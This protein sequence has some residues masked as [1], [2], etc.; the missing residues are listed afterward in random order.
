VEERRAKGGELERV[1]RAGHSRPSED[2]RGQG[3]K[4]LDERMSTARSRSH[5]MPASALLMCSSL[6]LLFFGYESSRAASIA[7]LGA[8]EVG[9]GSEALPFTVALGSPAGALVL[10]LYARSI[11]KNGSRYT[12]RVSNFGCC[13]LLAF[14]TFFSSYF[15]HGGGRAGQALVIF[16]YVFREIYVSL[17]STQHWSFLTSVLDASST[18]YLVSSAGIVSISSAV[19]SCA[20]EVVVKQGGVWQ[21]LVTSFL[22]TMLSWLCAEIAYGITSSTDSSRTTSRPERQQ[23]V[24]VWKDSW[25]LMLGHYTLK[26]LFLEAIL[27]QACSNMLNLMFHDGLRK[28]VTDDSSRA[29][30]V[31]RFFASVNIVA[32]FLQVVVMPRVLSHKTLPMFIKVVPILVLLATSLGLVHEASLISV[33]LGFGCMKVLE[34]SVMT[35]A[36]EMIYMPMGHEVRYL[37]KEL[38]RFFGHRLGKS[39]TSLLLSAA[40]A[41]F[42]PTLRAQ[43]VWSGTLAAVWGASMFLLSAHLTNKGMEKSTSHESNSSMGS[44]GATSSGDLAR[45][46]RKVVRSMSEGSDSH[47]TKGGEDTTSE[48]G[49]DRENDFDQGF[50]YNSRGGSA[51]NFPASDEGEVIATGETDA[52]GGHITPSNSTGRLSDGAIRGSGGMRYRKRQ[53]S[54]DRSS[55]P[56]SAPGVSTLFDASVFESTGYYMSS[57]GSGSKL[58]ELLED[59]VRP[60]GMVRIGSQ[61]VSLNYLAAL[62]DSAAAS[63]SPDRR[64]DK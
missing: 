51:S 45:I 26:L 57:D 25:E 1:A 3:W 46:R 38:I 10:Y 17:L 18:G 55:S 40:S 16:F 52:A 30:L 33:M 31:G 4:R 27:H 11:K 35:S 20:V 21:L 49:S 43:S 39:G 8:K 19:G 6:S 23:R 22:A 32:C 63:A 61:H 36:M 44:S 12:L 60:I 24:T 7:L 64:R 2:C 9:L 14:M 47:Q 41:H 54:N 59:D 34:Y 53:T 56:M 62:S 58:D 29:A 37:G 42:K 13:T 15:L 48:E 5:L 28:S 50:Y